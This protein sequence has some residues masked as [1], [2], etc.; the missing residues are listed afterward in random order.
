MMNISELYLRAP[1]FLSAKCYLV[2]LLPDYEPIHCVTVSAFIIEEYALFAHPQ[3]VRSFKDDEIFV[4]VPDY[5]CLED[6]EFIDHFKGEI[7]DKLR[8]NVSVTVIDRG[9]ILVDMSEMLRQ[10]LL[11]F[12]YASFLAVNKDG[13]SES[14]FT[15]FKREGDGANG[16]R[17]VAR[18][19][20]NDVCLT[21]TFLGIIDVNDKV[22]NQSEESETID[23]KLT[24]ETSVTRMRDVPFTDREED[25]FVVNRHTGEVM[26][27]F[28]NSITSICPSSFTA[29]TLLTTLGQQSYKR[30]F[31]QYL[32]NSIEEYRDMMRFSYGNGSISDDSSISEGNVRVIHVGAFNINTPTLY[33]TFQLPDSVSAVSNVLP[34]EVVPVSIL[35]DFTSLVEI[36]HRSRIQCSS[37]IEEVRRVI[38]KITIH[39][40]HLEVIKVVP[41]NHCTTSSK[42]KED[43]EFVSGK[44][45]LHAKAAKENSGNVIVASRGVKPIIGSGNVKQIAALKSTGKQSSIGTTK[46]VA[47]K[48]KSSTKR[49]TVKAVKVS[50]STTKTTSK[51]PTKAFVTKKK[52]KKKELEKKEKK[53]V[54]VTEEHDSLD[55][56]DSMSD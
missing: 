3:H 17:S 35:C 19:I 25:S 27:L 33:T 5:Q 34:S 47:C 48:I 13:N 56:I 7:R 41:S 32:P 16:R 26:K 24:V 8:L 23:L 14:C 15:A 30:G 45:L 44:D 39:D 55:S 38:S 18:R 1:R 12:I 53:D 4:I 49:V 20:D 50:K 46:P 2:T 36:P 43:F 51:V 40:S 54:P 31:L 10:S 42:R 9:N 52:M 21:I 6:E 29:N 11:F 28:P 22:D 37:S